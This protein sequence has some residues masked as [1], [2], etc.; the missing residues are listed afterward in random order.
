MSAQTLVKLGLVTAC[1][2]SLA[3]CALINRG[4]ADRAAEEALE[5]KGVK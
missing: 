4:A 2:I 3:G 1:C 5:K